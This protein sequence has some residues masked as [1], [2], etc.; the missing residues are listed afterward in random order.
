MN[1]PVTSGEVRIQ[2]KPDEEFSNSFTGGVPF[3]LGLRI[4]P[5]MF[6][7]FLSEEHIRHFTSPFFNEGDQ[8]VSSVT[9]FD[10]LN[11]EGISEPDSITDMRP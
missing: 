5:E 6:R 10:G 9:R 4:N 1:T 8:D 2:N 11:S 7:A 3:H